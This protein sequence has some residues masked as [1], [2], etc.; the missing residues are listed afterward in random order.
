[1]RRSRPTALV[2]LAA[3]LTVLTACS[4]PAP[5]VPV[6]SDAS[7]APAPASVDAVPAGLARFYT[8]KLTWGPCAS[9]AGPD[10]KAAFAEKRYDCTRLEVPLDYADP[11]GP[12]AQLGVLRLKATGD[13]IG[14]LVVNP[15]G[16]GASGMSA[17]PS[18]FGSGEGAEGPLT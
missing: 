8:Q 13:K 11:T 12:T 10:D 15:G 1:V 16:P 9:F 7:A 18:L 17:V 6:A 3:A 4:S 5:A 2:L 14:S